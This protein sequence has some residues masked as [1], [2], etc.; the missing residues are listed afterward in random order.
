MIEKKKKE[1]KDKEIYLKKVFDHQKSL[2]EQK[3]Q[4][5]INQRNTKESHLEKVYHDKEY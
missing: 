2:Q 3:V 4:S 1:A 5:L